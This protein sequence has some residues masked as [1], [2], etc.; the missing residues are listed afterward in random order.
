MINK[1]KIRPVLSNK[2]ECFQFVT[3]HNYKVK[4]KI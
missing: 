3:D 4:I 1:L 2:L